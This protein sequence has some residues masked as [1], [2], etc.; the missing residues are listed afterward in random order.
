MNIHSKN[1]INMHFCLENEKKINKNL[2]FYKYF[3][4]NFLTN[5]CYC[6]IIQIV[7]FECINEYLFKNIAI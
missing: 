6:Y 4:T 2:N 1:K 3:S 7:L 5:N